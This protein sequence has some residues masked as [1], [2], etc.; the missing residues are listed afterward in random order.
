[1]LNLD[2]EGASSLIIHNDGQ[3][4]KQAFTDENS[5]QVLVHPLKDAPKLAVFYRDS[6]PYCNKMRADYIKL[7]EEVQENHINLNVVAIDRGG[8]NLTAHKYHV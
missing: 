3:S 1:M 4:L 5:N 6:C 8:S 2:F 7:A